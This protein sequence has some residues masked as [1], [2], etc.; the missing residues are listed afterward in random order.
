MATVTEKTASEKRTS[1]PVY[2]EQRMLYEA[3]FTPR[4]TTAFD[5]ESATGAQLGIPPIY[6]KMTA[7]S[8]NLRRSCGELKEP[9]VECANS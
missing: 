7:L 2:R 6:L 4:P 3:L 8:E 5:D 9:V 1:G